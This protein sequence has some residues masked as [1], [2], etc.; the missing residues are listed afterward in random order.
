MK[1]L[2]DYHEFKKSEIF[3]TKRSY[4]PVE[5]NKRQRLIKAVEEEGLTIKEAAQNLKINYSTAKHIVKVYKKTGDVSTSMLNK[6]KSEL[7]I[8]GLEATLYDQYG[9]GH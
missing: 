8:I 7:D 5:N 1:S 2:K 6:R 4:I 9:K 3:R